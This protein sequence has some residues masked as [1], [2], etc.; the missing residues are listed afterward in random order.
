MAKS[1]TSM[2]APHVTGA[3]A[4][5]L[6]RAGEVSTPLSSNQIA[7]ALRQKTQNYSGRWDRG[8]GFGLVDVTA[9]LSAFD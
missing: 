8:Q 7:A 5:L 6:S 3:V 4:L 2:A 9:L 1:G